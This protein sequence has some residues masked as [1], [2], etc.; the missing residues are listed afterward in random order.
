MAK[1]RRGKQHFY[2]QGEVPSLANNPDLSGIGSYVFDALFVE[3]FDPLTA[4]GAGVVNATVQARLVVPQRCV[5]V[6]VGVSLV[7]GA[8]IVAGDA[9]NIVK[10][11][12]A[13]SGLAGT[14]QT[15]QA[16]GNSVFAVDKAIGGLTDVSAAGNVFVPDQPEAFYDTG[17]LLTLRVA[18]SAAVGTHLANLKVSMLLAAIDPKYLKPQVGDAGTLAGADP[19]NDF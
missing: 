16:T 19:S 5:I 15:V 14:F 18:T 1:F 4:V 9:F 12:V 8:A 7:T 17:D 11:N 10:N 13:E 6:K 2:T 3:S